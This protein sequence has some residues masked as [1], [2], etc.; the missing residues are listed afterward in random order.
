[1]ASGLYISQSLANLWN[2]ADDDFDTPCTPADFSN[3]QVDTLSM[4]EESDDAR[5]GELQ[6]SSCNLHT[7]SVLQRLRRVRVTTSPAHRTYLHQ[8]IKPWILPLL[9]RRHTLT[10]A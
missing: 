4:N 7:H 5:P 10:L 2:E 3:V 1:M 8:R 9:S 6:S